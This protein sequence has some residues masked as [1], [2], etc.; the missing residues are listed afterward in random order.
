M[1]HRLATIGSTGRTGAVRRAHRSAVLLRAS[2]RTFH[3]SRSP[4]WPRPARSPLGD[5]DVVALAAAT[6]A[7]R[8]GEAVAPGSWSLASCWRSQRRGP[9]AGRSCAVRCRAA[10]RPVSP[11][12]PWPASTRRR[13]A[14]VRGWAMLVTDP[15]PLDGGGLRV[16]V[17]LDGRRLEATGVRAAAALELG[18]RLAGE[19]IA[20]VG[21]AAAPARSMPRG[22]SPRRVVGRLTDRRRA[23]TWRPGS[24]ASRAANALRRTLDAG[25][26][27]LSP[28]RDRSLLVGVV[29]GDDRD[30]PPELTDDFRAAGLSHL[31][32]GI[33]PERRVRPGRRSARVLTRLR[34]CSAPPGDAGRARRVRARWCASNRRCCGRWPWRRSPPF[35]AALGR[36]AAGI[37]IL[38]LAVT[39]LVL[40]DPLLVRSVG[41]GLSVARVGGDPRAGAAPPGRDR[42][43]AAGSPSRSPSRWPPRSARRPCCSPPSVRCRWRR[44]RQPARGPGRRAADDLGPHRRVARR[45]RRLGRP[46]RS[47][48]RPRCSPGG[49][50]EV[51][52]RAAALPLGELHI[53]QAGALLV[54]RRRRASRCGNCGVVHTGRRPLVVGS[55]PSSCSPPSVVPAPRRGATPVGDAG[56][57]LVG[58]RAHGAASSTGRATAERGASRPCAGR[59][60]GASTSSPSTGGGAGRSGRRR[61]V[62]PAVRGRGRR[63]A[64]GAAPDRAGIG[65][66][67]GAGD[68][69]GRPVASA[70]PTP[71]SCGR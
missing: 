53:Q 17:R 71:E 27:R 24:L 32:V 56:N 70:A 4:P 54:A 64:R 35:A 69:R 42:R 67:S 11:T 19:R 20:V 65:L 9:A 23:R 5:R 45:R 58:G 46:R 3:R 62:A 57:P 12:V 40:V 26:V 59:A 6:A 38:G 61:R 41:F 13:P 48:S 37:R 68:R 15:E 36:P 39:A 18:P 22:S 14:P 16:D 10:C 31:L 33:G 55:P 21:P 50:P 28:T 47:T 30:Q 66:P 43:A 29:L 25:A 34:W 2:P 44:S 52:R 49:W 7:R 8:A 60:P 63:R 1:P 51:A